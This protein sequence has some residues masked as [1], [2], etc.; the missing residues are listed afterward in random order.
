MAS[1]RK[2]KQL[3]RFESRKKKLVI[4]NR[5]F[6][7]IGSVNLDDSRYVEEAA[8][9]VDKKGLI[10]PAQRKT[11]ELRFKVFNFKII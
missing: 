1:G 8:F 4:Y 10:I 6:E 7:I 2:D 9:L 3:H 5:K 11:N